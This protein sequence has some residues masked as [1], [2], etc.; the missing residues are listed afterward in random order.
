[1]T[2][3]VEAGRRRLGVAQTIV[4]LAGAGCGTTPSQPAA[5]LANPTPGSA[6][7]TP[8]TTPIVTPAPIGVMTPSPAATFV[9]SSQEPE[10]TS[11]PIPTP[12]GTPAVYAATMCQQ[13]VTLSV[14][15][16]LLPGTF[17]QVVTTH[18]VRRT[19]P[20][21]ASDSVILGM[22]DAPTEVYVV[23]GPVSSDGY[24]WYLVQREGMNADDQAWVASASRDG[25]AWLSPIPHEQGTWEIVSDLALPGPPE[26]DRAIV[27]VDGRI[28]LFGAFGG[29]DSYRAWSF[30]LGAC[31]WRELP[32]MA[33]ARSGANV[34][35]GADG[36]LYAIGGSDA[37][38]PQRSVEVYLP[39][40]NSWLPVSDVPFPVA[41]GSTAIGV[42]DG[43]IF[44]LSTPFQAVYDPARG[45]WT[46]EPI[47]YLPTATGNGPPI[48]PDDAVLGHDGRVTILLAGAAGLVQWDPVSATSTSLGRPRVARYNATVA[49]LPDGRILVTGGYLAGSCA[50]PEVHAQTGLGPSYPLLDVFDP[51]T[52][53]WSALPPPPLDVE[54]ASALVVGGELYLIGTV[55]RNVDILRYRPASAA[56][57]SGPTTP[58]TGGCGG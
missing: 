23:E 51:P 32:R 56:L 41:Y 1:M 30:D 2:G 36:R 54:G 28:Y 42:R 12:S 18:L 49:V 40:T 5:S 7:E 50:L 9:P 44:E 33:F 43:R 6:L 20:R 15:D 55:G 45:E 24:A 53:R 25:E 14:P 34:A 19:A 29:S 57:A 3:G 52:G 58:G 35:L 27:G 37:D 8:M 21:I 22:M 38:G 10:D 13:P 4:M 46:A 11:S 31:L 47:P 39:G 26:T 16:G 17:G 48:E